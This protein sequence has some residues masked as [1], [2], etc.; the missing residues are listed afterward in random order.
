MYGDLQAGSLLR[1]DIIRGKVFQAKS[2]RLCIMKTSTVHGTF[3]T[4]LVM[5]T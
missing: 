4:V 3:I 2:F 5:V 1:Q